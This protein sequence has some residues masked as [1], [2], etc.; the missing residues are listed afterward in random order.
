MSPQSEPQVLLTRQE[1]AA[2]V[3]RLAAEI[4]KDYQGKNPLL[5]G[6]LKGSF[7]F[8]ADLVRSLDFPLTMEFITFSSYRRG[9]QS[10]RKNPR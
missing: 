6:V 8:M 2:T 7:I 1:I 10:F 9:T 4:M 5:I 3:N